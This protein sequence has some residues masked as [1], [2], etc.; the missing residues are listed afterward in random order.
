MTGVA[1]K[2]SLRPSWPATT[3]TTS[4]RRGQREYL[5]QR[6]SVLAYPPAPN[7]DVVVTPADEDAWLEE[8]YGADKL[9]LRDDWKDWLHN[10]YVAHG[11]V[12]P[13]EL[14]DLA[15]ETI[16]TRGQ[17]ACD[18]VAA[19]ILATLGETVEALISRGQWGTR[20]ILDGQETSG[21][22]FGSVGEEELAVEVADAL[23]EEA[24]DDRGVWPQCQRHSAGLHP[25]L[26][27]GRAS[28]VCRVG[29]HTVAPI[30]QLGR[31]PTKKEARR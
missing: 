24:M 6:A 1:A 17:R 2:A 13:E 23:Q 12:G 29:G 30:G 9:R 15:A 19:D 20:V 7:N 21:S 11:P 26:V 8:R 22:G 16:N 14:D 10:A 31:S 4:S 27:S 5:P 25:E 18:L 28:W 3:A